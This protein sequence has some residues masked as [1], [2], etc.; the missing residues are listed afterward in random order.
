MNKTKKRALFLAIALFAVWVVCNFNRIAADQDGVIRFILG[1]FFA[2]L[3]LFRDKEAEAPQGVVERFTSASWFVPV[4]AV[5]GTILTLAGIIFGVHQIEWL[6]MVLLFFVCLRWAL[7]GKFAGDV[8]IAVFLLYW[9]HP[10]PGQIFGPLQ[11]A[12]QSLT[13]KGSEWCLHCLNVRVWADGLLLRTGFRV[14]GVP[15]AC[16]GM[17]TIV[18][19]VLSTFGLCLLF[20]VRWHLAL[21]FIVLGIAQ[22]AVLNIARVSGMVFFASKMTSEQGQTFL[23]DTMGFFLL[24]AIVLIQL[25]IYAYHAL[26]VRRQI[27]KDRIR[28]GEIE[29]PDQGTMLPS[30]WRFMARAGWI[31]FIVLI[32]TAVAVLAV[33][34]NNNLHRVAMIEGTVDGLIVSD[35][36]AASKAI[37]KVLEMDPGNRELIAKKARVFVLQGRYEEAL[38]KF[39]EIRGKLDVYEVVLK[40]R[41]LIELGRWPE[42]EALLKGL[43]EVEKRSPGVA[44]IKAEYAALR[45]DPEEVAK[46]ILLASV[47]SH[48][49]MVERVRSLFLYLAEHEQW[50][51]IVSV[52]KDMS[53]SS[54][55]HALTAI[56]ANLKMK[57]ITG[58][59]A[60]MNRALKN[61]PHDPRLLSCMFVLAAESRNE[62]W[63]KVFEDVLMANIM[64]LSSDRLAACIG[65]A[66]QLE[67]PDLAWMVYL[68][69][70]E[71]DPS[72]PAL[73]LAPAQFGDVWFTFKRRD[74]G[75]PM[76]RDQTSIDMKPLYKHTK[77][78]LLESFWK[79]VPLA[80]ELAV[81]NLT[82]VQSRY[83][84]L[85][86]GQLEKKQLAG[87][88]WIDITHAAVL[89]M[90]GRYN[91]VH[92][93][94]DQIAEK[95]P[96]KKTEVLLRHAMLY[97][98]QKKWQESMELLV[99][100]A[101]EL[102][103]EPISELLLIN[104]MMN[105][106]LGVCAMDVV[107]RMKERYP[108]LALLN[109]AEASIWD[110]FGFKDQALFL[111]RKDKK[112][113]NSPDVVRLLYQSGRFAEAERVGSMLGVR[114]T[115]DSEQEKNALG[116][117]P[118]ELTVKR[119]WPPPLSG[120]EINIEAGIREKQIKEAVSPFIRKLCELE[121]NWLRGG[122]QDA[123]SEDTAGWVAAGRN[124]I[125]RAVALHRLI[126]LAAR[127][128]RYECAIHAAKEAVKLMPKSAIL[129]RILIALTEGDPDVVMESAVACPDDPEIWVASFV[130][131]MRQKDKA[132]METWALEEVKK[133]VTAKTFSPDTMLR[134]SDFLVKKGVIAPAVE[135]ARDG[136]NR[137]D[138]YAPAYVTGLK[139]AIAT[140]DNKWALDCI[141]GGA[142]IAPDPARFYKAL[143]NLDNV[144]KED[145]TRA[146]EY[147]KE[148]I[149]GEFEW[150]ERLGLVYFQKGDTRRALNLIGQ[151]IEQNIN[152][153]QLESL[154]M[155]A[156]SAQTE[157]MPDRAINILSAAYEMHPEK[158]AVLNNLIYYLAQQDRTLPRAKN[159][160][161]RLLEMGGDSPAVMDTVAL[162]YLRSG[163]FG[164]ADEY[165]KKALANIDVGTDYSPFE[166]RLNAAEIMFKRGDL[167]GAR[168]TLDTILRDSSKPDKV[169]S[170]ARQLLNK[171]NKEIN[172]KKDEKAQ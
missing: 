8:F 116:I 112:S 71:I 118:A 153:V 7:P 132:F 129:R 169:D 128:G 127:Q 57:N 83:L 120:E 23:H 122:G 103:K 40:S 58:A 68:R 17:R 151:L 25:E 133:A 54:F 99:E 6:G 123:A 142:S 63:E 75:V 61:W 73:S 159:L 50:S 49:K 106:N 76:E 125:E 79:E 161:P 43:S 114:I 119:N 46:N 35:L 98:K 86:L 150:T 105:L 115:R 88:W 90:M 15:E 16:S 53:Y 13:V 87:S 113:G 77:K 64:S 166:I 155:A 29:R 148:K 38:R 126:M 172:L 158:V 140:G 3:I 121:L 30:F 165:M 93:K 160:L 47:D 37:D 74:I 9:I 171:V 100:H 20:R 131:N 67:R 60:A 27:E 162:V 135:A 107:Q 28:R 144:Q 108:G 84:K 34:R 89:E 14:F 139:C 101:D 44:M 145:L 92:V 111:L 1:S 59:G 42:A 109:T 136:I 2:L 56:Y 51:T 32:F 78:T 163:D 124:D 66:F 11:L 104:A 12:M 24:I 80:D 62:Q 55:P 117:P 91:D 110:V 36:P 138:G 18:T 26:T 156:E 4:T 167:D 143:V 149:P 10:L 81:E 45:D 130:C 97:D 52:D 134:V 22:V 48:P 41:A 141:M 85:C 154:L 82:E 157:G 96:H 65:Y 146:L 19:V 21:C 137:S 147:L 31:W 69:L 33:A 168:Q 72:H 39:D 102:Q 70:N 170:G 94:L 5:A 164:R 95:Y 152:E